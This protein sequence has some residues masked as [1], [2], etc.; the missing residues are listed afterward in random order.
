MKYK[1]LL[2]LKSLIVLGFATAVIPLFLGVMY[3]A[4]GLRE[5]AELGRT[6]N[7]QVFEQTK[8]IRTVLQKSSDIER[9]ARLFVLLSD[10]ALRQPYERESYEAARASFKQSLSDLLKL[11]VDN[12]IALLV[13]ELSEKENLIYQQIIG[14]ETDNSFK[15]PIDEAF[16]GL[17]ESSNVLSREFENHVEHTFNE[18]RQLSESLEQ[19]LLI[20]GAILLMLSCA[21]VLALLNVLS[22]SM[23]QLD[24][25][26]RRLGSG[27]L[28]EPIEVSGPADLRYLGERLEW[29]RTHLISLESSKQQLMQNL[30]REIE[31]PLQ[32]IRHGAGQLATPDEQFT[33]HTETELALQM[34]ASVDKLKTV[35]E[36]LLKYSQIQASQPIR[37]IQI[38]NM[39]ELVETTLESFEDALQAKSIHVKKLIKPLQIEGIAEQ[40]R[41]IVEELLANAIQFSPENGEIRIMLRDSG[42]VME[43]EIEDDGPGIE[44]DTRLQVFEPFYRGNPTAQTEPG[45]NHG[46]GLAMVREYVAHHQGQIEFIDPRQDHLGA[47]VRVQIPLDIA[48]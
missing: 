9:K 33:S 5:T 13:N 44:P 37:E 1:N 4:Y 15:L 35:S 40:C 31:Q 27:E 36:Q 28:Q 34:E 19:G 6:I 10:P 48:A 2:S 29:L 20:K 41:G 23:R 43:L 38:L 45:E 46:L 16:Q 14:S 24:T 39:H 12:K 18:L 17:R 32:Q 7:S 8:T 47:R 25:A 30:A 42:N 26:I 11:H 3:A 21:L 22:G